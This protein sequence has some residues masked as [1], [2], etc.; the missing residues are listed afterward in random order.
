MNSCDFIGRLTRCFSMHR[1]RTMTGMS[2][3]KLE[4][5]THDEIVRCSI[6]YSV[7][8]ADELNEAIDRIREVNGVEEVHQINNG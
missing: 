2:M 1:K 8:S 4:S 7:H 5:E 3:R 6:S